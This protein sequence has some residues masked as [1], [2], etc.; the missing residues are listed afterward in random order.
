LLAGFFIAKT[1]SVVQAKGNQISDAEPTHVPTSSARQ[2]AAFALP[3][4]SGDWLEEPGLAHC[5]CEQLAA[6]DR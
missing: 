3:W 4:Q 1:A 6:D 2:V 5:Q